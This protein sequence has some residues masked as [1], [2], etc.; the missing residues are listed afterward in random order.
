MD[1]PVSETFIRSANAAQLH[2]EARGSVPANEWAAS[3]TFINGSWVY[4]VMRA[5]VDSAAV[6]AAI[7]AHIPNPDYGR[8]P[9]ALRLRAL[10][11]KQALTAAEV[12]EAVKL[13]IVTGDV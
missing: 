3:F 5:D 6:A 12:S 7:A 11:A 9:E 4:R 1:F 10:G 2:A 8:R 13:L